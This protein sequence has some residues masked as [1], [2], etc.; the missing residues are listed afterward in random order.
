MLH[1]KHILTCVPEA[2]ASLCVADCEAAVHREGDAV[3]VAGGREDQ[4]QGGVCDF[5]RVGVAGQGNAPFREY[6]FM[7]V[8]NM[9]GYGGMN[10]AG[11]NAVDGY[12]FPAQF[13]G[14]GA[15]EADDAVFSRCIGRCVRRSAKTFGG[16]NIDDAAAVT[17]SQM[18]EGGAYGS[19][20]G[21]KENR[22]QAVPCLAIFFIV[23]ADMF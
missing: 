4:A 14:H 21:G 20:M 15:G 9:G 1:Q 17:G 7:L 12:P 19:G 22:E 13:H 3:D 16:S 2:A 18:R 5:F 23:N 10:G 6:L 11:T 8:R